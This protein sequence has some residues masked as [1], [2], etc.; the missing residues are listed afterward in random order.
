MSDAVLNVVAELTL[1]RIHDWSAN[2]VSQFCAFFFRGEDVERNFDYLLFLDYLFFPVNQHKP[3]IKVKKQIADDDLFTIHEG[4]ILV[5]SNGPE[6]TE[7]HLSCPIIVK[8]LDLKKFTAE[9]EQYEGPEELVAEL[10]H[11]VNE[12][13]LLTHPNLAAFHT[14]LQNGT[15]LYV[16]Q[17]QHQICTLKTILESFGP[18]KEP[19]I[20]RYLLQMLQALAFL[21]DHG[22]T[23]GN[24]TMQ[25][26]H[27]DSY[28]L[29]KLE[30]FGLRRCLLPLL[31]GT[32]ATDDDWARKSLAPEVLRDCRLW[33]EK[34][35]VWCV[36]MLTL[37][38]ANGLAKYPPKQTFEQPRGKIPSLPHSRFQQST[39][40]TPKQKQGSESPET[41]SGSRLPSLP[42]SASK[43]LKNFVRACTQRDPRKR[44]STEELM[45]MGFFQIDQAKETNEVLRTVCTDLDATM[46]RLTSASPKPIRLLTDRFLE[47]DTEVRKTGSDADMAITYVGVLGAGRVEQL[48]LITL[49]DL[50]QLQLG[51]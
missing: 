8:Q 7:E 32:T 36:G 10:R 28:G 41:N 50:G 19:T 46:R 9:T 22:V 5:V 38:M 21:H 30:D 43:N 51:G 35:D 29:L 14:T 26:V 45:E 12:L 44:P 15:S 37:Q 6:H 33:G 31:T 11:R 3:R 17:E 27:I 13:R 23:H 20:R 18:M 25:T 42:D 16:V 47:G 2:E 48:D 39:T 49:I 4:S 1:F 24:L 34:T 40:R